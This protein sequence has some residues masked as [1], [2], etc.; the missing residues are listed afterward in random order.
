VSRVEKHPSNLSANPSSARLAGELGAAAAARQ[1]SREKARLGR[2]P[3][4]FDSLERNE[5][6]HAALCFTVGP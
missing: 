3:A 5:H 1:A 2:L 6:T 4:S